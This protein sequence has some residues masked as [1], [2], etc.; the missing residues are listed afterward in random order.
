MVAS[1]RLR[2]KGRASVGLAAVSFIFTF[3]YCGC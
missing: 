2:G 1:C 3:R